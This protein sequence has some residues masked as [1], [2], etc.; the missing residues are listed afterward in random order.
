MKKVN[1]YAYLLQMH[2]RKDLRVHLARLH[3]THPHMPDRLSY[4]ETDLILK[5]LEPGRSNA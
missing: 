1:A 2:A 4:L 5:S 3:A